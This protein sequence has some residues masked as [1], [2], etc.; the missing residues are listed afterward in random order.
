ME[1]SV[2]LSVPEQAQRL[3]LAAAMVIAIVIAGSGVAFA[4]PAAPPPSPAPPIPGPPVPSAPSQAPSQAPSNPSDQQLGQSRQDIAAKAS[5]VGRLS[6][7]LTQVE[8][9]ADRLG[10]TLSARQEDANQALA[11]QLDASNAADAARRTAVSTRSD[12]AAAA[13]AIEQAHQRLD[14][15]I[16][17]AYLQGVDA[18]SLGLLIEATDPDDLVRRA[19]LTEALAVDQKA[20]LDSLQRARVAKVNADSLARAAEEQARA[21]EVAAVA[22]KRT[23]D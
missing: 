17:A 19:E 3:A 12:A 4:D 22:A 11:D 9:Q 13:G 14:Q 15:F 1:G 2:V 21:T 7:Q 20:A 6:S 23:A 8:E 16:T 18:G 10:M 5:E